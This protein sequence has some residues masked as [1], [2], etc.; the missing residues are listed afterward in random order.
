VATTDLEVPT[1]RTFPRAAGI[2]FGLGLGGFFDGIVFN[3]R[4][5]GL[6]HSTTY[7]CSD[8]SFYPLAHRA[9]EASLLVNKAAD[10]NDVAGLWHLQHH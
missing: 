2:L 5:D 7:F 3:T 1:D 9:A 10:G 6:F 4:W 8:R